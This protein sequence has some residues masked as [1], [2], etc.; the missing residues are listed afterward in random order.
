MT[1][2]NIFVNK[3]LFLLNYSDFS[4]PLCKNCTPT[5]RPHPQPHPEK[6]HPCLPQQCPSKNCVFVKSPFPHFFFFFENLVEDSILQQKWR[7]THYVFLAYSTSF[8]C[9]KCVLLIIKIA[10]F[11]T[12]R[13][14]F[15]GEMFGIKS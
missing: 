3:L 9:F 10:G 14:E 4:L 2:E 15:L 13:P 6:S 1:E 7:G 5:P 12:S 8:L 11:E